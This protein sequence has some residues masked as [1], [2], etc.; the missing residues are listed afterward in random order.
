MP[1][2]SESIKLDWLLNEILEHTPDSFGVFNRD[3]RLVFCNQN[4]ADAFSLDKH[5]AIG[6]TM[7]E[8]IKHAYHHGDVINI[9]TDDIEEWVQ[10]T[11]SRKRIQKHRTFE[12]DAK[13]GTWKQ[14]TELMIDNDLLVVSSH[15]ITELK[16]TQFQLAEALDKISEI[17]AIDELTQVNNRRSFNEL[18]MVEVSKSKRYQHPLTVVLLDIDHFKQVNDIHGHANGDLVLREFAKL[19]KQNLRDTDIFARFG[20]EEFVALLPE[21]PLSEG[22]KLAERLTHLVANHT[23]QLLEHT[24]QLSITV[25]SGLTELYD[26]NDSLEKMLVRAD[27]ALYLSKENGR[28]QCNVYMDSSDS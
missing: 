3:N 23:I 4:M 13:D 2:I 7:I 19:F 15:D 21:T 20:G 25:S 12:S 9:E 6:K 10:D 14:I 18:A 27:K 22:L 8:L 5:D 28:N 1:Y 16:H 26:K 17:A 11:L 24:M